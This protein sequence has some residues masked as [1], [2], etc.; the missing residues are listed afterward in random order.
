MA[1]DVI[2]VT[3]ADKRYAHCLHQLLGNMARRGFPQLYRVIAYDLGLAPDTRASLQA[4]YPWCEMRDFPFADYPPHVAMAAGSY[5]FKPLLL[6]RIMAESTGLVLWFDS[7]TLFRVRDLSFLLPVLRRNGLYILRGQT[8][9]SGRCDPS[10]LERLQVPFFIRRKPEL[11]AGVIGFDMGA[12][13]IRALVTTWA[14]HARIREDIAPRI[15][16]LSYH[17]PEQALLTWLAYAAEARG[18]LRLTGEEID[19]SSASPVRWMTSRNF[20]SNDVP[21]WAGGLVRLRHAAYKRIDQ[22]LWKLKRWQDTR[23]HGAHRRMKEHFS[24]LLQGRGETAWRL[25]PPSHIYL[26]DPFVVRH[27]GKTALFVERFDYRTC[28]GDLCAISLDATLRPGPLLPILPGRA[29]TSFPYTFT[30]EGRLYLVPETSAEGSV[31]IHACEEF[32]TRWRLER[33]VLE[34]IDAADSVIFARGGLWWLITAVREDG[35]RHLQIHFTDD[36]LHGAWQPHPVNQA[37]LWQGAP[38]SS[39]RNGGAVIE[40]DGI[41]LRPAQVSRRFYGEGLKLMRIEVLTPTKYREAPY[42]GP[43]P[44]QALIAAWSPHHI[45]ASDGLVAFDIRDRARGWEGLMPLSLVK[46]PRPTDI[47]I[48]PPHAK[49]SPLETGLGTD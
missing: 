44:L 36:P 28:L 21:L 1:D 49:V 31:E 4:R 25:K 5:A 7:A 35:L 24:V 34:D 27:Q 3:A 17:R 32:P 6:E 16:R 15:P 11:A 43:D 22:A 2:L 23:L 45:S 46:R 14:A 19:V 39:G 13:A 38:F 9:L 42:D 12:P 10:V 20:V 8:A 47:P 33:I 18:E 37:R 48:P 29:H 26:A 40:R 30:H 41:L